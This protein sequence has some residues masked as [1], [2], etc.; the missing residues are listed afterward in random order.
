MFGG[1]SKKSAEDSAALAQKS[2]RGNMDEYEA[3]RT[4]I[5][6]NLGLS[7]RV[8]EKIRSHRA[9]SSM[10]SKDTPSAKDVNTRPDDVKK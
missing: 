7:T 2:A 8:L 3:L 5:S 9:M 1:K 10:G 6:E 4:I